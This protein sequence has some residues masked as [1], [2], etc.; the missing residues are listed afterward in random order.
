[1]SFFRLL[2]SPRALA[3][4]GVVIV[5]CFLSLKFSVHHHGA[6][7]FETLYFHV[8]P[9]P[10]VHD[11]SEPATERSDYLF[12]IPAGPL[13]VFRTNQGG[14]DAHAEDGADSHAAESH[15]EDAHAA[16]AHTDDAHNGEHGDDA[17]FLA[18]T[19]LQIFQIASVLLVLILFA[20]VP[21]YLRT[22]KGDPVS[23]VLSGFVLWVRDEMVYP[24]MGKELGTKFLPYFL[25]LFFFILFMNLMGLVPGSATA[26]ASIYVTG[27]LALTTFFAMVGC[28]MAAQGP[29]AFVKNLVPHVPAALWPLMLVVEI[30]GLLIKP[31]AL[32]IRLFANMTGGHMVVLSFMGLIFFFGTN[33]EM[34]GENPAKFGFMVAPV[35]VGFGVFIMIIEAFVAMLQAFIFTQ[36]TVIFV[37]ASVHPEH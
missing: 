21:S 34:F 1:M 18:L 33:T 19:N 8:V 11:P 32:M 17:P 4:L 20:G 28:G 7:A 31:F 29:V 30:I 26:T 36:L 15:A 25:C 5:A 10:L 14:H 9:A 6:N 24:V 2:L 23:R 13:A 16:D 37:G 12:T 22:G 27:A 35:A 3:G